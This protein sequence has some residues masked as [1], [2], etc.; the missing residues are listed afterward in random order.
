M[1]RV[2][3]GGPSLPP[4]RQTRK[5]PACGPRGERGGKRAYRAAANWPRSL[6]LNR[7]SFPLAANRALP[8]GPTTGPAHVL[9]DG[10]QEYFRRPGGDFSEVETR[11]S[12]LGHLQRGGPPSAADA[13][14]AALFADTTWR[15]AASR[16]RPSGI[17][18]LRRGRIRLVPFGTFSDTKDKE[19]HRLYRLQKDV[20]RFTIE[21]AVA[22]STDELNA[23]FQLTTSS[24]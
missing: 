17:V 24:P 19:L 12:V 21:S 14:L 23:H 1:A 8:T 9:A 10:L 6:F 4:G 2:A 15:A 7:A 20:S 18:T 11:A 3:A 5:R 13:I 22:S 16:T